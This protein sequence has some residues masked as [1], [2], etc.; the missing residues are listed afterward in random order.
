MKPR[1]ASLLMIVLLALAPPAVAFDGGRPDRFW[2]TCQVWAPV[3]PDRALDSPA[4]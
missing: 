1:L 2:E 3:Y 4:T